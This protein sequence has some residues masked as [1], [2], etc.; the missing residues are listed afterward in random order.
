M[1]Y[2]VLR[3]RARD[4]GVRKKGKRTIRISLK[5][6]AD[7]QK[8]RSGVHRCKLKKPKGIAKGGS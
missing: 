6:F 8:V 4:R 3:Q 7:A 1:R 5:I 2:P